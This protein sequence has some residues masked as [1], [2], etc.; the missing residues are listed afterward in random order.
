M[1]AKLTRATLE[2]GGKNSVAF[3]PDVGTD[4]AVDGI[5]EAGFLHSGQICAAASASLSIARGSSR[6]SKRCRTAW[7]N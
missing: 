4:K 1:G 2:L 7:A 3:L 5:I 6:C